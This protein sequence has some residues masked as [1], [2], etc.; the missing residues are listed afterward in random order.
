MLPCGHQFCRKCARSWLRDNDDC[1]DCGVVARPARNMIMRWFRHRG[2][3]FEA[4]LV[5]V[6]VIRNFELHIIVE[7]QLT[8]AMTISARTY[9]VMTTAMLSMAMCARVLPLQRYRSIWPDQA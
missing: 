3:A 2:S 6:L 5:G 1:P 9:F 8:A 7:V 4:V